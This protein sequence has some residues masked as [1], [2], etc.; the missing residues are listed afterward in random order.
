[1]MMALKVLKY[2]LLSV[3]KYL[4]SNTHRIIRS[5]VNDENLLSKV[6]KLTIEACKS[7]GTVKFLNQLPR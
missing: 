6:R 7:Q 2:I 5:K 3:N 1:M 4:K